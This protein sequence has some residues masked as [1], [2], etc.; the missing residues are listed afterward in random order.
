[1]CTN[2]AWQYIWAVGR[3]N[4]AQGSNAQYQLRDNV[5]SFFFVESGS[6]FFRPFFCWRFFAL[7]WN[8]F[9]SHLII[10]SSH[11]TSSHHCSSTP[12]LLYSSTPLRGHSN[13]YWL[14]I[15]LSLSSM[16]GQVMSVWCGVVWC[17]IYVQYEMCA[18]LGWWLVV[19]PS[20][21]VCTG[22][23]LYENVFLTHSNYFCKKISDLC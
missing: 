5:T 13:V 23:L 14:V 21:L 17:V 2:K 1:M 8:W 9:P 19:C 16:S 18:Q 20:P 11:L 4:A 12:L 15:V 10:T 7:N 3:K 22:Q 6:D